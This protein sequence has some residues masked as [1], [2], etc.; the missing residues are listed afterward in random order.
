MTI[1]KLNESRLWGKLEICFQAW[2]SFAAIGKNIEPAS[3]PSVESAR[4][5]PTE[6]DREI[7]HMA[8]GGVNGEYTINW[9]YFYGGWYKTKVDSAEQGDVMSFIVYEKDSWPTPM[10]DVDLVTP[11]DKDLKVLYKSA[12]NYYINDFIYFDPSEAKTAS[13][14]EFD[15]SG[16]I[17]INS[18]RN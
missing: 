14:Y 13:S 16:Q 3:G 11:N 10:R 18:K 12:D 2:N 17:K 9:G 7:K 4:V 5:N 1:R 15:V 6:N 8:R